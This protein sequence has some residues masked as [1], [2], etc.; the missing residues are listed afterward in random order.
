MVLLWCISLSGYSENNLRDTLQS[1]T[2]VVMRFRIF[3]PVGKTEL[4]ED[5]MDN[6][7][8]LQHIQKY[9]EYSSR[10]DSI[11]IY[12]YGSPDGTYSRNNY[13]AAGRGKTL[14]EYLSRQLPAHPALSDS[15]LVI[16]VTAENWS[17]LRDLVLTQYPYANRSE[18]LAV[19]D[20]TDISDDRREELLIGLDNGKSWSYMLNHL[21]PQL[22]FTHYDNL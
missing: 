18:V 20:C 3:Y 12:S 6:A 16:N 4:R 2:S 17:G 21:M 10:I 11:T 1:D 5:Y 15:R 9:L 14:Q 7:R 19:L 13:L 22:Y 8:T